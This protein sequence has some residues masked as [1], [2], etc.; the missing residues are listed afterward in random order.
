MYSPKKMLL[1]WII[2]K[3]KK[4]PHIFREVLDK[5]KGNVTFVGSFGSMRTTVNDFLKNEEKLKRK[6]V[7]V[8]T[9]D[10]GHCSW[11]D[12]ESYVSVVLQKPP[13]FFRRLSEFG[14]YFY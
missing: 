2:S 5:T 3:R 10:V 4:F 8:K 13:F 1:T 11:F 6:S 7:L 12:D 9:S 14:Y